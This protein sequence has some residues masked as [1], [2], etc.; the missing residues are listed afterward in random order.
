LLFPPSDNHS[1]SFQFADGCPYRD[2]K[3]RLSF[4]RGEV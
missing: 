3:P 1:N 4:A 2:Q